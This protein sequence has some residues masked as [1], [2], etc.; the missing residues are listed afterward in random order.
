MN[1]FKLILPYLLSLLPTFCYAHSGMADRYFSMLYA[2][3]VLAYIVSVVYA[4]VYLAN[5]LLGNKI[6]VLVQCGKWAYCIGWFYLLLFS[7][8][9]GPFFL[10]LICLPVYFYFA[11]RD[12]KLPPMYRG[13][14]EFLKKPKV[15]NVL[16]AIIA[17]ILFYGLYALYYVYSKNYRDTF[18]YEIVKEYLYI[19]DVIH[20]VCSFDINYVIILFLLHTTWI[21]S[22]AY[23]D[24]R[25]K[26]E[27]MQKGS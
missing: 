3:A 1:N 26:I 2:I 23:L 15:N 10:I 9:V 20:D 22:K 11:I 16:A 18:V 27:S 13:H 4:F 21:C 14:N 17:A 12:M 8:F 7:I 19:R 24:F 6:A 5:K 25:K